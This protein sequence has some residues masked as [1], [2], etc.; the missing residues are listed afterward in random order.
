MTKDEALFQFWSRFGLTAY[1]ETTVPTGENAPKFPYLTYQNVTDSFGNN[2]QMAA[3][4]WYRDTGW[5]KANAKAQEIADYIG[6][7]GVMV[8]YS[9]GAMWIRRGTPFAQS[10]RDDSDNMIRRK[11]LNLYAEFMSAN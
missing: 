2:V 8:Q 6:R 5:A 3:S 10:M 7:G 9:G 4:V 11:Y 1:E